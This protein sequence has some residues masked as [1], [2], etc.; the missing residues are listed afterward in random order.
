[1]S[2]YKRIKI[3]YSKKE[4]KEE[5]IVIIKPFNY[6]LAILKSM[7]AFL[8]IVTHQFN[9]DSTKNKLILFI[10]KQRTFHVPCFCMLSFNFMCNTL[11]SLNPKKILIRIIRLLIPYIGWP[12]IIFSINRKLKNYI[13]KKYVYT[14]DNL[15]QQYFWGRGVL[16]QFWFSWN[17]IVITIIFIVVIF[18]FR[19]HTLIAL[20]I[21][22]LL[23][24]VSQ[25]TGYHINKY[26]NL[27]TYKKMGALLIFEMIPF[28]VT[29]FTLGFYNI[30]NTLQ[31]MKIKTLIYSI[32]IYNFVVDCNIFSDIKG[33][34]FHGLHLNIKAVCVIFIFSLFPS[35][36]ITNDYLQKFLIA[37]TNYSGGVYYLHMSMMRYFKEYINEFKKES[38][39]AV[40]I[41]YL[42]C[43]FICF[44]G[45]KIFG[46]TPLKYLFI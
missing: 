34:I 46:K 40:V 19:K 6:G 38:F 21:L 16:G 18:I 3:K 11:L 25:Y 45:T 31:D 20:H 42:M 2:H 36:K 14:Y 33:M 35:D 30:I 13:N 39:W 43:Y 41:N 7:C 8:V 5:P 44:I 22:M 12:L 17:L 28:A 15:K 24:Y 23:C 9:K 1:M 27:P 4:K 37:V 32:L 26:K 10:T 29:G